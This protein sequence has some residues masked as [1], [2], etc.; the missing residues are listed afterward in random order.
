MLDKL[1]ENVD[2]LA[3]KLGLPGDQVQ[4]IVDSLQSKM[5]DGTDQISALMETAQEHG[6]SLDKIQGLLGNLD[7]DAGDLLEKAG[8][9]FGDSA[10]DAKG[11]LG[12]LMGMAKGLLGK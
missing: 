6:L 2:D 9:L 12:G 8:N 3:E 4:N 10:E 1:L 7:I 5:G 11:G